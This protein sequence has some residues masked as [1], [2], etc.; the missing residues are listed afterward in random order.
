VGI[1]KKG[2]I[3]I[4]LMQV[5]S[6]AKPQ[7]SKIVSKIK[8]LVIDAVTEEPIDFAPVYLKN[9]SNIG[10]LTDENGNFT[11][12]VRDST[13]SIIISCVG[14][15]SAEIPIHVGTLHKLIV[16]LNPDVK[17]LNAVVVKPKKVKYK[18]KNNPAV[19]LIQKIIENKPLNRKEGLDFYAFEKYEKLQISLS[20]YNEKLRQNILFKK[21]QFVFDNVDT[22]SLPGKKILPLF[23]KEII[24]DDY[25]KKT[26]GKHLEVTQAEKMV[27]YDDYIHKKTLSYT[28]Q[29][30]Y[31]EINIYDNNIYLLSNQ[32]LSPIAS[33]APTFYKYFIIDTSYV[34]NSKCIKLAFF[35][36]NKADLLFQ[37]HLYIMLDSTYAV[38]KIE[39]TLNKDINLNWVKE[40]YIEQ[41]FEKI[42]NHG[43]MLA[44]DE[45]SIDFG[46]SEE[47]IGLFGQRTVMYKNY[48]FDNEKAD[49]I[50]KSINN[51]ANKDPENMSESYWG[52]HR[53][54][55]LT[56]P[57]QRVYGIMDSLKKVPA[58]KKEMDVTVLAVS[59][60][61][62]SRNYFEIGP[63]NTFYSYNPIEGSRIKFGGRTT[64]KFSKKVNV[65]TY[66]AFGT[67]DRKYKYYSATSYS[68]TP[69]TILDFPVKNIKVSYQHDIKIPGQELQF[70]QENN[71]LL[72]FKRGTNDK[73]YYNNTF[74]IEHL[75]EFENHFS[76]T[77]GYEYTK[78]VPT[79]D[80]FFN[81]I[82]YLNHADNSSYINLSQ[83]NVN[84][85]YAPHEQFL[86][87]KLYRNPIVNKYPVF[88]L[89]YSAGTT[90]TGN[91]YDYQKLVF[92]VSKRFYLSFF[93]YTDIMCETG[94][95]FGQVPYPLLDVHRANQTYAYQSASYNL[96]NFLE[97]VSD[98][99][100]AVN[101]QHSFNGF[102]LNKIPLAKKLKWRE[103]VAIKALQGNLSSTNDPNK[104]AGLYKLP[105]DIS[106][107][108]IT[109]AFGNIPYVEAS[110]GISNIFNILRVDYVQRLTYL[111]HPNISTNGIRFGI[112]F[113][114]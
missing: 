39:L 84:L 22:F 1:L 81:P 114:F 20:D 97:F 47:K 113:D 102:F 107:K 29:F 105:V 77:I 59:G 103:I 75:N 101:V 34:G 111:N 3:L 61:Y 66:G 38:K 98:Q 93:G 70:A 92:N 104:Q 8:G 58:F 24:A 6:N 112:N 86:Q 16:K 67:T 71:I 53:F 43:F 82:N 65:E 35:P 99:Y 110:I 89:Q 95:I 94:K 28:M 46:L 57:E 5:F 12:L 17:S 45:I 78:E 10:T 60:F 26:N 25:Y 109:Y 21:F 27:R 9:Q 37:G 41:E 54:Q 73:M 14:Y 30:L 62:G 76:Y 51:L 13:S 42:G 40:L 31:Q 55:P 2:I 7:N 63:A 100:I 69:K 56:L 11:F 87:A 79:G 44:K 90:I 18:N 72:S 33:I 64:A 80:L 52:N 50:I 74:K 15:I 88:Q 32:F 83:I 49:S 91:D 36:R 48:Q 68:L 106:G 19:E 85:R 108:P 23:L 4:V 96:M